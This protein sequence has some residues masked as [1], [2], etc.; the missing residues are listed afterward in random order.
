MKTLGIILKL[1]AALVVVAG[2]IYVAV[3]YGD[4]IIAWVKKVFRIP[5]KVSC[6]CKDCEDCHCETEDCADC[7]CDFCDVCEE[8]A[9]DF[10]EE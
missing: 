1:L 6:G 4:K 5:E 9:A 7:E 3:T 8:D 2:V 10:E